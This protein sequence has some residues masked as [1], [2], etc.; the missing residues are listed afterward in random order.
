MSICT[1]NALVKIDSH[2]CIKVLSH[3]LSKKYRQ[4]RKVSTVCFGYIYKNKETC[5]KREK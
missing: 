1:I 5:F 2:F 4:V 3:I